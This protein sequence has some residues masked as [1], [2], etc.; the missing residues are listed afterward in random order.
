MFIRIHFINRHGQTKAVHV[1]CYYA[2]V[3]V[4][5][6]L[7][8][9]RKRAA[10]SCSSAGNVSTAAPNQEATIVYST[11]DVDDE[12]HEEGGENDAE[13]DRTNFLLGITDVSAE[14]EE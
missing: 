6:R 8:E 10:S 13:T 7:L 1:K 4:E 14:D 3:S 9:W 2:P 11:M 12:A 5:S